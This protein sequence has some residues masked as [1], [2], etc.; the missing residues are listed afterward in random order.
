MKKRE[1]FCT[2]CPPRPAAIRLP[3]RLVSNGAMGLQSCGLVTMVSLSVN[4]LTGNTH[5]SRSLYCSSTHGTVACQRSPFATRAGRESIPGPR[6]RSWWSS[7][8]TKNTWRSGFDQ[9]LGCIPLA[10]RVVLNTCVAWRHRTHVALC[11]CNLWFV[12]MDSGM[13]VHIYACHILLHWCRNAIFVASAQQRRSFCGWILKLL[14]SA[15]SEDMASQ[16]QW[17][18]WDA[19]QR[20]GLAIGDPDAVVGCPQ[21]SSAASPQRNKAKAR[22]QGSV[23]GKG[24]KGQA[25]ERA[26]S[27]GWKR[28]GGVLTSR[29][30]PPEDSVG[31]GQGRVRR[32]RIASHPQARFVLWRRV[33]GW[34][35]CWGGGG[36]F[37]VRRGA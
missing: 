35:G 11:E 17:G 24:Q 25:D 6:K 21:P 10:K 20:L 12:S 9:V 29:C 33:A 2:L 31:R 34:A 14:A 32:A 19:A 22:P 26:D 3:S 8:K 5:P 27:R 7:R 15:L 28:A 37:G 30:E 1:E 23:N 16:R 4:A 18:Q 36:I 13:D